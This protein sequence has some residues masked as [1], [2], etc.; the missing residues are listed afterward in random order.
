[1]ERCAGV[2]EHS[3]QRVSRRRRSPHPW[4]RIAAA[5]RYHLT[6]SQ[7]AVDLASRRRLDQDGTGRE[8]TQ[9]GENRGDQHPQILP[10]S[11]RERRR[12]STAATN[13][14]EAADEKV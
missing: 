10:G 9:L 11:A 7:G 13:I 6:T 1:M 2:A 8:P 3:P 5:G 14:A 4:Q 12:L